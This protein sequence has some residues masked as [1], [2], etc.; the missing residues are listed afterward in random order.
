MENPFEKKDISVSGII[1]SNL[2][3]FVKKTDKNGWEKS[4]WYRAD[5]NKR[6]FLGEIDD[7]HGEVMGDE[8][9]E[10]VEKG[11]KPGKRPVA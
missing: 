10:V 8:Y 11:R 1:R 3:S 9:F 7:N 6:L 4:G 5:K 2:E